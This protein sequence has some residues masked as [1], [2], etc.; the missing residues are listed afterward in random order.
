MLF[1]NEEIWYRK[2]EI[3]ASFNVPIGSFDITDASELVGIYIQNEMNLADKDEIVYTGMM[4]NDVSC[5]KI[6]N[7]K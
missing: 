1:Y 3:Q 2:W 5:L 7:W 4:D 6:W